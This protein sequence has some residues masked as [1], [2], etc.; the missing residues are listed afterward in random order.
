M[1]SVLAIAWRTLLAL[2]R[3]E[4][5]GP[6]VEYNDLNYAALYNQEIQE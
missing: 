5:G 2:S 1:N 4:E 3:F 6:S